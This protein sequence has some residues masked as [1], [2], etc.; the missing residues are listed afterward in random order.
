MQYVTDQGPMTVQPNET[1]W[2]HFF[3]GGLIGDPEVDVGDACPGGLS[4]I[5]VTHTAVNVIVAIITLGI[6][7]PT[8]VE[9]WCADDG[10]AKPPGAYRVGDAHR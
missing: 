5:E 3:I 6:Y 7:S 4:R 9:V 1:T 10:G 2:N 8:T